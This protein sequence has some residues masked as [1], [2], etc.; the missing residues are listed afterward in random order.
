MPSKNEE[1][2]LQFVESLLV[3]ADALKPVRPLD[4]WM[5][6]IANCRL[7]AEMLGEVGKPWQ[8]ILNYN[9]PQGETSLLVLSGVLIAIRDAIKNDLLH[10]LE[11]FVNAETFDDLLEQADYLA[12]QSFFMAAGVLGRAVLEQHL[13]KWCQRAGIMSS[14]PHPTINDYNTAIY[15]AKLYDK[16]VMKHVDAMTAV[17]NN[18]AHGVKA[19]KDDIERLLRDVRDFLRRHPLS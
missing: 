17:G 19:E 4:R 9:H 12:S 10:R 15:N 5:T 3:E 16:V 7:L 1:R 14:K 18:A 6:F 2:V 8:P 13:R 11:D